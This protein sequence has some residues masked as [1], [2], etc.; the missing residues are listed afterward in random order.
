MELDSNLVHRAQIQNTLASLT[1]ATVALQQSA[2]NDSY[3]SGVVHGRFQVIAELATAT[4]VSVE[5][6]PIILQRESR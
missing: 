6:P 2:A 1:L 3:N 4:G 5:S